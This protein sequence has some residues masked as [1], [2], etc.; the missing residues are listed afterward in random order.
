MA[1]IADDLAFIRSMLPT[2]A[3]TDALYV[4]DAQ[5]NYVYASIVDSS[6]DKTIAYALKQMCIKASGL[7]GRSNTATGD[8]IQSQ[9]EREAICAAAKEWATLTGLDVGV[10]G[11][12]RVGLLDEGISQTEEDEWS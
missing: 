12:I 11:I 7:V 4:T 1:L 6:I 5:L 10:A 8:T 3:S 2:V 9:Q